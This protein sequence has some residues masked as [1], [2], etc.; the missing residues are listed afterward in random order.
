MEHSY[1]VSS[2]SSSNNFVGDGYSVTPINV[3]SGAA[4]I[5]N[6][7]SSYKPEIAKSAW[8]QA[9]NSLVSNDKPNCLVFLHNT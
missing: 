7:F 9:M 4:V 8:K 3:C 5:K 2:S 1:S 6:A